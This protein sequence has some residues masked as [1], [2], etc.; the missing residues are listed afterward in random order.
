MTEADDVEAY[1]H[2]FERVAERELWDPRE[3]A[4]TLAPFLTGKAQQA[5]QDLGAAEAQDYHRLKREILARAGVS[6]TSAGQQVATWAYQPGVNARSQMASLR[7]LV[8]RWLQPE[9]LSVGQ[10]L[11]RVAMDRFLRALP[12]E[13]KK[14]AGQHAPQSPEELVELVERVEATQEMLKAGSTER[15]LFRPRTGGDRKPTPPDSAQARGP[16]DHGGYAWTSHFPFPSGRGG[17][18]PTLLPTSGKSPSDVSMPTDPAPTPARLPHGRS[19]L[20]AEQL[21]AHQVTP[22]LR[23]PVTIGGQPW[24]ALLDS[25]SAVTLIQPRV[26]SSSHATSSGKLSLTCVHGDVHQVPAVGLDVQSDRGCWAVTA[27]LVPELPVPLL[28]GRNYPGFDA[29]YQAARTVQRGGRRARRKGTG[30]G[31]R[32]AKPR[33]RPSGQPYAA[34][35]GERVGV[36]EAAEEADGEGEPLLPVTL[37]NLP[38]QA[39]RKG[40]F[41][42]AQVQDDRLRHCWSQVRVLE[43]VKRGEGPLEA[44]YFSVQQGLLHY[45]TTRRGEVRELLVLPHQYV[46]TVL[47]LAHTHILGA[48]L[49]M[50]KTLERVADRFHWPGMRRAVEDYCRSCEVCQRTSPVRPPPAPLIPLPIIETPFE[51]IGLDLVGPLP[52]SA[53]GHNYILV[54]LDYATRYPE[55][56]PLRVA[57]SKAI[58]RELVHLVSRVGIPKEILTDQGTPFMSKVMADTCHLLRVQ[59]LRTSVYHPQT[60]GLVERFNQTLKRMLRKIVAADGKDWDQ[61]LPYVLFAIREVPQASTGFSPFELLYGRRPRGLLDLAKEAWEEQPSPHPYPTSPEKGLRRNCCG[62]L[63]RRGHSRT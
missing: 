56:V 49:G 32:R 54:I 48:H 47:Q 25:G 27:G 41:G 59:H 10:I 33:V 14:L 28:L 62:A 40:Q 4:D 11:D 7:R 63:S 57:T 43:G 58:A 37:S 26:L 46:A 42:T 13:A 55:A 24:E 35:L 8:T 20:A 1:L 52:K 2:T 53:R 60:D 22:P 38:P 39:Q 18:M 51:R 12:Y 3:M 45:H 61:V 31:S 17:K 29:L 34:W 36:G 19:C 6:P 16:G 23:W 15:P 30:S 5:Y 50:Q 21:E 44:N 9:S